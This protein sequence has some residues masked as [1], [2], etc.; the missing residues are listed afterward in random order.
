MV[1]FLLFAAVLNA[2]IAAAWLDGA[3]HYTDVP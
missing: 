3:I 1:D 2:L